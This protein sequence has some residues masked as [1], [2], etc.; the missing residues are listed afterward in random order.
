MLCIKISKL[1]Y[2]KGDTQNRIVCIWLIH[3][4]RC[5]HFE[6]WWLK[7]KFPNLLKQCLKPLA[8]IIQQNY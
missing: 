1:Q 3:L 6:N 5:Y 8:T 7:L 4:S 2:G